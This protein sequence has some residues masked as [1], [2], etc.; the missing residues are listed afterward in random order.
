MVSDNV[1]DIMMTLLLFLATHTLNSPSHL[2]LRPY[3]AVIP[4]VGGRRRPLRPYYGHITDILRTYYGHIMD[5]LRPYTAV[6][7]STSV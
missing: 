6:Y 1:K 7:G 2:L 4:T 5:I 3:A